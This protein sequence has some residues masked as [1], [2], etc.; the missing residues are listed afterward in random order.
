MKKDE[1][2]WTGSYTGVGIV[3]DVPTSQI[4]GNINHWQSEIDRVTITFK[5]G[6][7]VEYF[8]Q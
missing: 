5:D 4:A 2:E 7:S 8:P 3:P 1:K 6:T